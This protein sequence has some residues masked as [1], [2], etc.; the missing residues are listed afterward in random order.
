M[1]PDSID[2]AKAR[3]PAIETF[4][5]NL[6]VPRHERRLFLGVYFNQ[7]KAPYDKSEVRWALALSPRPASR[8]ASAR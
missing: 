6:P 7:Q 8:S 3:N 4:R 2:A 1:S 5:C